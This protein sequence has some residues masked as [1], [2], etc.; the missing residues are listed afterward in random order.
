M[1][2]KIAVLCGG[3]NEEREVS[4]ASAAMVVPVLRQ[5]KHTVQ[6]LDMGY[7]LLTQAGDEE[8]RV[9]A[10]PIAA[11]KDHAMAPKP[12]SQQPVVLE[13]VR[14]FDLVFIALHGGTGEDGTIQA[15]LDLM[16]VPYTGSGH[17]ASAVCMDKDVSKR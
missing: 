14:A 2:L 5:L 7:G 9:F 15:A 16:K 6:V 1:P 3:T 4:L 11:V 12:S 17:V 13:H 10:N 8:Q